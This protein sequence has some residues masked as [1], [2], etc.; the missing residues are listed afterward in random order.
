MPTELTMSE[1]LTELTTRFVNVENIQIHDTV[2]VSRAVQPRYM[3]RKVIIWLDN[4]HFTG[5]TLV[6]AL[7]KIP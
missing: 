6:E 3:D 2:M 7:A 5:K 4:Y 1:A